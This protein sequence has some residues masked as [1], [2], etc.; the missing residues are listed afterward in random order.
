MAYSALRVAWFLLVQMMV[1]LGGN[2]LVMNYCGR[3]RDQHELR[4][5]AFID[6][7]QARNIIRTVNRKR[8]EECKMTM[9]KRR[10]LVLDPETVMDKIRQTQ[11]EGEDIIE[12]H[13]LLMDRMSVAETTEDVDWRDIVDSRITGG[14]L[15]LQEILEKF[16]W[17]EDKITNHLGVWQHMYD[18]NNQRLH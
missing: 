11:A 7:I 18:S 6:L 1:L 4:R 13:Q 10:G 2:F 15:E 17:V 8:A 5:F 12:K 14:E 9:D 3:M 16:D